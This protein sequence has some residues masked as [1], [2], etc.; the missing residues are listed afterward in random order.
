MTTNNIQIR[1][2][3]KFV[4]EIYEIH[5]ELRFTYP[6]LSEEIAAFLKEQNF[7]GHLRMRYKK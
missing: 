5:K 4:K 2:N 1:V 3:P 7:K 6:R